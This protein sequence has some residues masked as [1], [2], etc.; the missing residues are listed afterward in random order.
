MHTQ[1]HK[2]SLRRRHTDNVQST[3]KVDNPQ[4]MNWWT[5]AISMPDPSSPIADQ[6]VFQWSQRPYAN[7]WHQSECLCCRLHLFC[8]IVIANGWVCFYSIDRLG[9]KTLPGPIAGFMMLHWNFFS[10]VQLF[11]HFF[12]NSNFGC[13]W[14]AIVCRASALCFLFLIAFSVFFH[15]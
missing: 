2:Q 4:E 15:D 11:C 1:T 5:I 14:F 10:S 12:S 6:S 8:S 7:P 13:N 9:I 3:S